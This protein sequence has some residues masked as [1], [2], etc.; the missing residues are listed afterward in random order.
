[1]LQDTGQDGTANV[2][3]FDNDDDG[4]PLRET[5]DED[6]DDNNNDNRDATIGIQPVRPLLDDPLVP[7][8]K[9]GWIENLAPPAEGSPVICIQGPQ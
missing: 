8:R 6:D 2:S 3:P 5:T 9:D 1:M 7:G 4:K